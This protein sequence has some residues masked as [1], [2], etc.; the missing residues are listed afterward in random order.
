MRD[1]PRYAQARG[2]GGNPR[3]PAHGATRGVI[4]EH[5][6]LGSR[7]DQ[8][9]SLEEAIAADGVAWIG[10]VDPTP[11]ELERIAVAFGLGDRALAQ[12]VQRRR[13][14]R[15]PRSRIT[16]LEHAAH[17]ILL[18]ARADPG[19][20]FRIEGNVELLATNA[21]VAVLST[22]LPETL[23]PAAFRQELT[24]TASAGT[25]LGLVVSQVLDVY[26]RLLDQLEDDASEITA[27][28]FTDRDADQLERISKLSTPV[29]A[30]TVGI[31]PLAH[32]F[33]DLA[34]G[35]LGVTLA[36]ALRSETIHLSTRLER[37]DALL[38]S[39][40]QTYFNLAQDEANALMER[41]GDVTRMMSGYALLIAI[42]TIA[43]SLYGTNFDHVPLIGESWGYFVML[44][45]TAVV[46][47]LTWWRL[48]V[49]GWI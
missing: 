38:S 42:P 14:R 4:V 41:Q 19:G 22:A 8:R 3:R 21:G 7:F 13:S 39:A 32:G 15:M 10:C 37:I 16:L 36:A 31:Q 44:G 1:H 5:G 18:G 35:E 6:V 43:F 11:A 33:E 30:A 47:L 45:V 23:Q 24:S 29:H 34:R 9:A 28:L 40:Q 27:S 46:C 25:V 12:L 20:G 2:H 49:A 26:E 17:L 48:R